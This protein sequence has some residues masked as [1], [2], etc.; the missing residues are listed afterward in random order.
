MVK[1]FKTPQKEIEDYIITNE[2]SIKGGYEVFR[3]YDGVKA[4]IATSGNYEECIEWVMKEIDSYQTSYIEINC[5]S[6]EEVFDKI[7]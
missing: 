4:Y 1:V 5:D 6:T 7:K 3:L 2:A